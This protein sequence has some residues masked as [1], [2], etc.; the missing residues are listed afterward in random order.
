MQRMQSVGCRGGVQQTNEDS[1]LDFLSCFISR[2]LVTSTSQESQQYCS[3]LITHRTHSMPTTTRKLWLW[4]LLC[5]FTWSNSRLVV[6]VTGFSVSKQRRIP[7]N[8]VRLL[9]LPGFGNDQTDYNG[10]VDNLQQRGWNT[11]KVLPVNRTDWFQVFT[12]GLWDWQFWQNRASATRPAFGWYLHLM[13]LAIRKNDADDD[14]IVLIGHSAGGWLARA[15][16]GYYCSLLS[17][18]NKKAGVV[19]LVTLGTPHLPPP[20]EVMDM[21]RGALRITNQDFPGA[22]YDE[23]YNKDNNNNNTD[24]FYL[25]VIG[26]SITGQQTANNFWEPSSSTPE[27]F[28]F[29]SYR[30]V[31][32]NGNSPGDG[33][34]PVSHAHLPGARQLELPKVL[35]SINAP[36]QWYGSD[37]V[38]DQW[39]DALLDELSK[40]RKRISVHKNPLQ[41][42]FPVDIPIDQ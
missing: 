37:A 5:F 15:A 35:H 25:T 12:N 22:Y 2:A 40:R 14:D 21:T 20:P 17:I 39:H 34:V 18:N 42:F 31:S 11:V 6:I 23:R 10:F 1:S 7:P 9:I 3:R 16:M 13:S 38:L 19:G 27:S 33:V 36:E 8:N 28:A 41:R 29:R 4:L 32:G 24:V 30:A 26:N